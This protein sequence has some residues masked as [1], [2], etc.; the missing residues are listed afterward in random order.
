VSGFEEPRVSVTGPLSSYVDGFGAEL[1]RQGYAP[2]SAADQV[3]LMAH[4]SRWLADAG[5]DPAQLT[6]VRVEQFLDARRERYV[7]LV[8]WRAVAPLLGYLRALELIPE[9]PR[10]LAG[11]PVERLLE[12]FCSYLLLERS[13]AAGSVRLYERVA[14]LFLAERSVPLGAALEQLGAEAIRGF[15]LRQCAERGVS[16][17]RTL[18]TALRALLRFLYLQGWTPVLLLGAVPSVAGWS[19]SSLPRAVDADVVAR[20]LD[21]CDRATAVGC[22]DYAILLLLSRFGLRSQEV[23]ALELGDV[24]W[25]AGELTIRGKGDRRDRLP[26]VCDVGSALVAYLQ[27]ARP[28]CS[29][30]RLFVSARAPLAPLSASAVRSVVRDACKRAGLERLGAHQLRHTAATEMLRHGAP[31]AEI[32]QVLRHRYLLTTAIYAKVDRTALAALARP[33]PG[34]A[35]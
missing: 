20:L 33:W 9:A 3:R 15:V 19:M 16:S 26:L 27:R 17:A 25:R 31:L 32:G 34:T 13:L 12:D 14:R 11:T 5:L 28:A 2:A 8:S 7:R 21:S 24:D 10:P 23:A 22:R 30:R 1:A 6:A 4:V 18:V 29:C 35:A